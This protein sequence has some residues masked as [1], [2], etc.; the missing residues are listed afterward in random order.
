MKL[1]QIDIIIC[2]YNSGKY[3][4]GTVDSIIN[5]TYK[6]WHII[7][8]DDGSTDN[9]NDII[10]GYI[11]RDIPITHQ[12]N[13]VNGGFGNA[14]QIALKLCRNKWV[15]I[16]DHDDIWYPNKLEVQV[17]SIINNPEARLFFSNS[18][19]F[20][21]N[22]NVLRLNLENSQYSTG[23]VNNAFETLI[24]E[25]CLIDSE[26]V[27]ISRLAL[28]SIGGFDSSYFYIT[29]YDVFL[30]IAHKYG[31]YFDN[32]ILAK[33]RVHNNQASQKMKQTMIEEHIRLFKFV[34]KNYQLKNNIQK[35]IRKRLLNLYRT[36]ASSGLKNNGFKKY[37]GFLLN[38][39]KNRPLDP[40]TYLKT[41]K[42]FIMDVKKLAMR[43]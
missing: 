10:E 26:T 14:R 11:S 35:F 7:I 19:W 41:F 3:L 5:Q 20:D 36:I 15:A 8:V 24:L 33:W 32:K 1:P 25:G 37:V 21:D 4:S 16:L 38:G 18:E 28:E 9:T 31:V 22:G 29:D 6:N 17:N 2:C 43:L 34:L 42:T 23:L 27:I 30:K 13:S 12:K 40:M 39:I